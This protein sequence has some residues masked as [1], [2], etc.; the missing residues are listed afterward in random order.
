MKSTI[1]KALL[2][3]IGLLAL[4][5]VNH[6]SAAACNSSYTL[7]AVSSA[8]FSCSMGYLT[9]SNFNY[10]YLVGV[11]TGCGTTGEPACPPEGAV[12]DPTL[13]VT[14]SFST[15][16][17]GSDLFG[18]AASPGS[19]ITQVITDYSAGATVN[20]FQTEM[21]VVQYLVTGFGGAQITEVDAVITG[22]ASP[23]A[24][25]ELNKNL[26]EGAQFG[27]GAVPNGSC[28][29]HI[30][31]AVAEFLALTNPAGPQADGTPDWESSILLSSAG[32]YDEWDLS[33]G[34][35]DPTSTAYVT[36]VENDFINTP[37]TP[38]PATFAML[39]GGLVALGALR[40]RKKTN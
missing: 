27:G 38:E 18:T 24:T 25:G 37:G 29:G 32:V 26:C 7:A 33:G 21:G 40:R 35:T 5:T 17:S 16:T 19:P 1:L 8:G 12:P 30:E 31:D 9:F 15:L 2:L 22:L 11:T 10:Q 13:D 4:G 28:I 6:L 23:G 3:P 14:V 20:E 34:N 39:G 36:A